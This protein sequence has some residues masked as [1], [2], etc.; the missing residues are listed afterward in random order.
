ME[1]LIWDEKYSVHIKEFDDQ[2]K[3]LFELLNSLNDAMRSGQGR[4][5]IG[6]II[7]GLIHYTQYHFAAEEKYFHEYGYANTEMHEKEHDDFVKK[8]SEFQKDYAEGKITLTLEVMQFLSQW[9]KHHILGTDQ[10]YSEFLRSKGV[11]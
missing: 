4:E 10:L 5:V 1:K 7:N 6:E 2:H 8:V 9:V 11:K 3:K